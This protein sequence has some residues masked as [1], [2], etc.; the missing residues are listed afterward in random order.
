M[1][2]TKAGGKTTQK[3]TRPGKRL[4]VKLF[5]GQKV[6]V[7]QIIVRQKGTRFHP[8]EGVKLGR[9]F[10]LYAV[11]NGRVSFSKRQGKVVVSVF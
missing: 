8:G 2:K 3:T 6:A 9:D 10:T 5:G 1:A 4:G 11:R 7:G